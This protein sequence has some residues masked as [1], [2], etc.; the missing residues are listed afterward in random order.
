MKICEECKTEHDESYGSG[1]FCS[2]SCSRSF[3]KT[4]RRSEIKKNVIETFKKK[5]E[6][7][8]INERIHA[9][10]PVCSGSFTFRPT[11]TR[12][13]TFCSKECSNI[14]RNERFAKA[15]IIAIRRSLEEGT[16][17]GWQSRNLLSYPEKFFKRVLEGNGF[18]GKFLI[19]FPVKKSSLGEHNSGSNY[20]LDFYFPQIQFDLEIDGKQ[21]EYQD[22]VE[23]DHKRDMLLMRSGIEVYRIKWL[24][25][26]TEK[27][28]QAMN[29]KISLL[30]NILQQKFQ[31]SEL[32]D[33]HTSSFS[34]EV[35]D[36]NS[37]TLTNNML[38]EKMKC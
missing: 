33:V 2:Q 22:R 25:I 4:S 1:R 11:K 16:H 28:R 13:R 5:R 37:S 26:N 24:S 19:N 21:H 9:T 20:F 14:A 27:G 18:T 34:L 7:R 10:C 23:S 35:G 15:G 36:S 38:K 6:V 32:C 29:C 3:S 31:K 8:E 17:K 30:L 12:S